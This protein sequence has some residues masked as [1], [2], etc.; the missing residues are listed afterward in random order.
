MFPVDFPYGSGLRH[1]IY[2]DAWPARNFHKEPLLH[3]TQASD[4]S[5][6]NAF[7][8]LLVY[9]LPLLIRLGPVRE[10]FYTG[11]QYGIS[12]TPKLGAVLN[13]VP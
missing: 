3:L 13:P 4:Q 7:L 9:T 2:Q 1:F 11:L 10:S 6:I 12:L 8:D 5:V